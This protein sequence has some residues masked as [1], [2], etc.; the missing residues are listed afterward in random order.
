MSNDYNIVD[1]GKR[2]V[3]KSGAQRD[4]GEL[5]TRPDLISPFVSDRFGMHLARGADKYDEW[6]W[7]KGMPS[8]EC[9]AS[10]NRHVMKAAQGDTVED[11]LAAIMFNAMVIIHN[12]E[13]QKL[14]LL[15]PGLDDWP[16][17]WGKLMGA[18]APED[19]KQS[20]GQ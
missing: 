14:G 18:H 7:A 20:E 3:F 10:L 4:R 12:Q 2:I 6:N 16:I 5:K 9:W 19:T 1:T 17:N 8:S 11:H 15:D 13:M